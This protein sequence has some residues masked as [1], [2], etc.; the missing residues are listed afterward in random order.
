[1][2]FLAVVE[3]SPVIERVLLHIA[4][5]SPSPPLRALPL[6]E[7]WPDNSQIPLTCHSIPDVAW[8]VFCAGRLVCDLAASD[9]RE[10]REYPA[11]DS[12]YEEEEWGYVKQAVQGFFGLLMTP[13]VASAESK[14]LSPAGVV[15][16]TPAAAL[17]SC[18][19]QTWS[20]N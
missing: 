1:M 17:E 5:W 12:K 4:A 13:S 15:G 7:D 9:R 11:R 18:L 3:E 16:Q 20:N 6:G 10:T 19:I 2:R 14:C 8:V